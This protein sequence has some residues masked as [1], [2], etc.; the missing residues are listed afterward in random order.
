MF[1]ACFL[2]LQGAF[3]CCDSA[4]VKF[5]DLGLESSWESLGSIIVWEDAKNEGIQKV[6]LSLTD[7]VAYVPLKISQLSLCCI[8]TEKR[9]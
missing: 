4:Q 6:M 8:Q 5:L 3:M 1:G 2:A 7:F 9:N